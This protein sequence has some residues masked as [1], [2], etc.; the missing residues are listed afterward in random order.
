MNP[1]EALRQA[2]D[3]PEA[4]QAFADWLKEIGRAPDWLAA[5]REGWNAALVK[6]IALLEES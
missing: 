6:A 1:I 5:F 4:D 3:S 2:K